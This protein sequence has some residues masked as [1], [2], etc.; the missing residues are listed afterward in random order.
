MDDASRAD[1]LVVVG[2]GPCRQ[3]V[4]AAAASEDVGAGTADQRVGAVAALH[5]HGALEGG[6][7][8]VT[9]T[10]VERRVAWSEAAVVAKEMVVAF[11]TEDRCLAGAGLDGVVTR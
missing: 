6:E 4:V 8:V 5:C 10:A 11:I 7:R 3:R 1:Q 2:S 9:G